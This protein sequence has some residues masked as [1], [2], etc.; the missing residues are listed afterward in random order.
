MN[1]V[2]VLDGEPGGRVRGETLAAGAIT[3]RIS[4]ASEE[5][6]RLRFAWMRQ[7]GLT[8]REAAELSLAPEPPLRVDDE[9]RNLEAARC[10]SD[11]TPSYDILRTLI[12]RG[13]VPQAG[14]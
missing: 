7:M 10:L 3:L 12:R 4:G 6:L 5:A 2:T 9:R 13:R 14:Q 11:I 8:E 1:H